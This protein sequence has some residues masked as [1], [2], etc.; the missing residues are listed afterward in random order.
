MDTEIT[1]LELRVARLTDAF[2]AARAG[3]RSMASRLAQLEAENAALKEKLATAATR[4]EAMLA[5]L[6][7]TEP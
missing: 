2:A 1:E 7:V 5:A 3:S 4:L 6:P